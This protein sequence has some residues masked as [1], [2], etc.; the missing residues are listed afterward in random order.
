MFRCNFYDLE[1]QPLA[2]VKFQIGSDV[3]EMTN[4]KC[5]RRRKPEGQ[6]TNEQSAL[7]VFAFRTSSFGYRQLIIIDASRRGVSSLLSDGG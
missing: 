6:M 4:D 5:E 2:I 7:W 1:I 3:K